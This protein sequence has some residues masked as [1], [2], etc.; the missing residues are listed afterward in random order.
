MEQESFR[1]ARRQLVERLAREGYI[2]SEN[3]KRAFL[4]VP[5]EEFVPP[6]LRKL[7]YVDAPLPTFHG[8]TISAPHMCAM[9]CELLQ[10]VPGDRV[11][12]IG[13]GSGYHAALCAEAVAP[14]S[15]GD[16]LVVTI[17]LEEKLAR[18]AR[19]NLS[20]TG[21]YPKVHPIVADG[22]V[23]LPLRKAFTKGLVTAACSREP[24][25]LLDIIV[26]GGIAVAPVGGNYLQELIVFRKRNGIVI[27]ERKGPVIFVPL[28]G[29]GSGNGHH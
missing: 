20:R 24:R 3:V 18:F 15:S 2:R 5:R 25:N 28:R 8:Q 27:K 7:A 26:D 11:A 13:T 12:E 4:H 19:D 16:G 17:E 14:G 1:E 6:R 10:P 29:V 23:T 9:M 21:Y 22:S